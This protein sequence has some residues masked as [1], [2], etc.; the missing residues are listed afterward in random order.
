MG[1]EDCA[2]WRHNSGVVG[3]EIGTYSELHQLQEFFGDRE[4]IKNAATD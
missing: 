2:M 1:P 4:D 3:V